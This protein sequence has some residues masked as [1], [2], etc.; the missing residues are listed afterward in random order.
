MTFSIKKLFKS[1][2]HDMAHNNLFKWIGNPLLISLVISL[3]LM[4]I[5]IATFSDKKTVPC[6]IK[7]F[8]RIYIGVAVILIIHNTFVQE[9]MQENCKSDDNNQMMTQ[10]GHQ[11]HGMS[12]S[13]PPRST[14]EINQL[15]IIGSY[16][17]IQ[18]QQMQM[19]PQQMQMQPQPQMQMQ[20]QPQQPQQPQMQ[21]PHGGSGS[22]ANM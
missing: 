14:T 16:A 5:L 20:M 3:V 6:A 21:M 11:V 12:D 15:P 22:L 2:S 19:Q 9:Q 8:I 1:T 10:V 4:I 13:I 7:L 18:Q 17:N